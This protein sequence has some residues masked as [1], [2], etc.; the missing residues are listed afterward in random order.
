MVKLQRR[1]LSTTPHFLSWTKIAQARDP[2]HF[3]FLPGRR[4]RSPSSKFPQGDP[5]PLL[6]SRRPQPQGMPKGKSFISSPLP[7]YSLR[8]DPDRRARCSP[9]YVPGRAGGRG[10]RE[11]SRRRKAAAPTHSQC[12]RD[13]SLLR[14]P[15]LG[16]GTGLN[17]RASLP[18]LRRWRVTL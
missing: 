1:P 6:Q 7:S 13:S 8:L 15:L 5:S 10:Q 3:V 12:P 17:F 18:S 14:F 4:S 16:W 11:E 2:T 9:P